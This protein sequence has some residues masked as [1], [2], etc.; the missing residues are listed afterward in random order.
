MGK[1]LYTPGVVPPTP[2]GYLS[3]TQSSGQTLPISTSLSTK[4][5]SDSGAHG[6]LGG[7]ASPCLVMHRRET[8]EP[9]RC[10]GHTGETA[11]PW[12]QVEETRQQVASGERGRPL[13]T[14][15]PSR[16][17]DPDLRAWT[18]GSDQSLTPLYS[19]S[20]EGPERTSG[21]PQEAPPSCP[22]QPA[23]PS[24]AATGGLIPGKTSTWVCPAQP[25]VHK[26][27]KQR[28][29]AAERRPAEGLGEVGRRVRTLVRGREAG[30]EPEMEGMG[31]AE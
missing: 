1:S 15:S 29:E 28:A 4:P 27:G 17:P 30:R 11:E 5:L 2:P 18:D 22:S 10:S 19:P 20:L 9:Q 6:G 21:T 3:D 14:S 12:V 16:A 7:E 24:L 23:A 8:A 31:E 25:G 13:P 26:G